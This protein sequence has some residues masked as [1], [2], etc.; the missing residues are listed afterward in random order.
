MFTSQQVI[1]T[2]KKFSL[3]KNLWCKFVKK[4]L[5]NQKKLILKEFL[6]NKFPW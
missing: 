4:F 1:D 2:T 3:K 6:L 5:E